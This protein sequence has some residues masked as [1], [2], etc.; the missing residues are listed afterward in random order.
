VTASFAAGI[1]TITV[2]TKEA[3]DETARKIEIKPAK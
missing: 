3:K 1:V 2:G